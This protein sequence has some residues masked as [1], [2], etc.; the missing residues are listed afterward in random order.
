MST[1]RTSKVILAKNI[2]LDREHN[3]IT[4]YTTTQM[5]TAL[6]SQAHLVSEQSDLSFVRETREMDIKLPYGTV[7]QANYLAFQNPDY[8]NKWFFA[9][10]DNVEFSS[11]NT[12][13]ITFSIDELATWFDDWTA[14]SCFVVREHTN[15]DVA[16]NNLI[17]ESFELGEYVS[18]GAITEVTGMS[19]NITPI[20]GLITSYIPEYPSNTYTSQDICGLP[21]AGILVCFQYFQQLDN[22]LRRLSTDAKSDSVS[23]VFTINR[24]CIGTGLDDTTYF[25]AYFS[26]TPEVDETTYYVFKGKSSPFTHSNT[27]SRPATL[28]GYTPVNQKLK[29]YPFMALALTNNTGVSNVLH[30]EYFS[31]PTSFKINF[32]GVPSVGGSILN[33]PENYKGITYNFREGVSGTKLPT[34]SWSKDAYTNWLTENAINRASTNVGMIGNIGG[35]VGNAITAGLATA[36]L[37]LGMVGAIP[38]AIGGGISIAQ[39]A[40][41]IASEKTKHALVPTSVNGNVNN[42]DVLACGKNYGT[43][44]IPMSIQYQFAERIDKFFTRYG[45]ATNMIKVPNQ[46]GR[47]NWNY[48]EIAAGESIGVSTGTISVPADA[49]AVINAAYRK[50][51]TIFHN[52]DNIGDFSLSN[53]IITP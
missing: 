7:I 13:K 2:K 39:S 53:S 20:I 43:Y 29:T 9:F 19:A 15:T 12:T 3:F 38:A 33:Y 51:V 28:N 45:Y 27:L 48:V 34:L 11:P 37:G 26:L 41:N 14:K 40:M 22:F 52:I 25:D 18:N 42:A 50:G 8:S 17:P 10:I 6:R 32:D 44:A 1:A 21:V 49:M 4:D 30:Y 16:G 47:T 31:D 35:A 24:G 23:I 36:S 5:L 46:T